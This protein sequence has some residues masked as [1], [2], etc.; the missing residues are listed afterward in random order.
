VADATDLARLRVLVVDDR[1][2]SQ[3]FLE[4]LLRQRGAE[5]Y[6]VTHASTATEALAHAGQAQFDVCLLDYML[7]DTTGPELLAELH[8]LDDHLPVI[9]VSGVVG[10]RE[11]MEAAGSGAVDFLLKERLDAETLE[12]AIRYAIARAEDLRALQASEERF[13][14]LA[15]NSTDLIAQL[16]PDLAITYAS[17]AARTVAGSEPESLLGRPFLSL[18]HPDDHAPFADAQAALLAGAGSLALPHRLR[19]ADG[20]VRWVETVLR[21]V[22]D[23]DGSMLELHASTRDITDRAQLEQQLHQVARL[24]AVGRL[25]G[26]LAHEYNNLLTAILGATDLV[27]DRLP[28]G[29]PAAEDARTVRRA[30]EEAARLTAQLLAFGRRQHLQ[31]RT[32]DLNAFLHDLA[33]ILP[34]LLGEDIELKLLPGEGLWPVRVDRSQLEQVVLGLAAHARDAMPDGG[35]LLVETHNAEL[36]PEFCTTHVGARPGPHVL[37][38]LTDTGAGMPGDVAARIFEPFARDGESEGGGG[39]GLAAIYGI[40]KQSGG[41]IW[42]YSEPGHGTTFKL[43]LPRGSEAPAAEAPG[44]AAAPAGRGTILLVEDEP[45]VR[46]VAERVL[47]ARGYTV[48]AAGSPAEARALMAG[49][50]A[51]VDLLITDVIMPGE[52]GAQLA[53]S[54]RA[55]HP[56][57]RVLF[58][59]GYTANALPDAVSRAE[60]AFLQKPFRPDALAERVRQLLEHPA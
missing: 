42:V 52:N 55:A 54:L 2:D 10:H 22:T 31:P 46:R 33:G 21:A 37:L 44:P 18:V 34:R 24:E 9:L 53:E 3:L 28:A 17:P 35:R 4:S 7:G 16:A 13:R 36:T 32:L 23:L 45:L 47:E 48:L 26:G 12:R 39:L 27:L 1:R 58:I 60:Q 19:R 20:R 5:R 40:M 51:P 41:N 50:E 14:L 59:S 30:A 56:G 43:Y 57:L 29:S 6:A 11:G 8:R 49:A 25:A 15:E 38:A